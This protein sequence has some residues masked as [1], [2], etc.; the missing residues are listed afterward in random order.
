MR[1]QCDQPPRGIAQR[2]NFV[3][4]FGCKSLFQSCEGFVKVLPVEIPAS[5]APLSVVTLK[6]RTPSPAAQLFVD[7]VREITKP[8]AKLAQ[9]VDQVERA[10]FP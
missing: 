7:C 2:L 1:R 6:G 4:E 3:A 8:L 5:L 9:P 10:N